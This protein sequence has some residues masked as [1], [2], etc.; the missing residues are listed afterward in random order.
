MSFPFILEGEGL[1]EALKAFGS[2]DA[3]L[4]SQVHYAL[5][6]AVILAH[7]IARSLAPV[8]T[9]RLRSSIYW[10]ASGFY[11]GEWVEFGASAPYA[12]FVEYGTRYMAPRP[13]M[14]PALERAMKHFERE[15][16]R[17]LEAVL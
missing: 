5:T 8:R 9:G 10:R 3:K 4:R 17:R 6:E 2:M 11:L 13:F 14:R 1:E 16:K 15:V 12:G 7:Q